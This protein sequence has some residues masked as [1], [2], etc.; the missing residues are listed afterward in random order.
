[1]SHV[2][3]IDKIRHEAETYFSQGLHQEALT[4][5]KKFLAH[6]RNLN[7]ILKTTIHESIRRIRSA[8]QHN[9]RDEAELMSDVEITLIKKGWKGHAT[10]EERLASA[11]ALVQMG[12]YTDALE[13]YRRLLKNRF[14]TA[15]VMRGVAT[16]LVNLVRPKHF[17]VVVDHFA[18]EIF[19]HPRNRKALKVIIAKAIDSKQ[20]PR[21]FSALCCYLSKTNMD[22]SNSC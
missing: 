2:F 3:R 15:A 14:L 7:P 9:N 20:Y 5:Y 17:T 8:A 18:G 10:D 16:C 6:T 19:K 11:Q 4:V 22:S 21:H 13:E 12:L 1:M